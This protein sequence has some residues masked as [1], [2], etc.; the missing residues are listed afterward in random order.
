M[1]AG[2]SMP[3]S[4]NNKKTPYSYYSKKTRNILLVL[5][6]LERFLYKKRGPSRP[7][8]FYIKN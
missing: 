6:N 5:K 3:T 1:L 8:L 4:I 7:L 2:R